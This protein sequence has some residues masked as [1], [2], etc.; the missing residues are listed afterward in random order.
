MDKNYM[1]VKSVS[2]ICI[3]LLIGFIVY[4]TKDPYVIWFLIIGLFV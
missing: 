1:I 4:Y 3:S 2:W